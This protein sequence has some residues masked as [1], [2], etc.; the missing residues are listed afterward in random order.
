MA[1]LHA[2]VVQIHVRTVW[3]RTSALQAGKP[4]K[5]PETRVQIPATALLTSFSNRSF[6]HNSIGLWSIFRGFLISSLFE[7]VEDGEHDVVPVLM[8]IVGG[9]IKTPHRL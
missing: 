1:A 5:G 2:V 4:S 7:H 8:G 9:I 6:N 3:S